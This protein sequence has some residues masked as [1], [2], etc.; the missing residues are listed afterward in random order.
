VLQSLPRAHKRCLAGMKEVAWAVSKPGQAKLVLIAPNIQIP[1]PD[2]I[3]LAQVHDLVAKCKDVGAPVIMGPSR[4][5]LG[6]AFRT[7]GT[8]LLL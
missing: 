1:C 8:L 4:K 5:Q 6:M 3:L 2:S 7:S